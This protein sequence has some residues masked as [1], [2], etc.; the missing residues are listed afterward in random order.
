M[1]SSNSQPPP[2]HISTEWAERYASRIGTPQDIWALSEDEKIW[3]H[4]QPF[5]ESKGYA[6]R[7]RYKPGWVRSWHG[8]TLDPDN[9]E[10]SLPSV[11]PGVMDATRV[12]DDKK[13]MIK[14][15]QVDTENGHDE[16][17]ILRYLA[18]D[19]IQHNPRNHCICAY[20]SF[21]APD[22]P[23]QLFI[24]MPILRRIDDVPFLT[25]G[26][27]TEFMRQ[28]LE[29]LEFMHELNLAHRDCTPPNI[30]MEGSELFSEEP[31]PS[32]FHSR[33]SQDG[34][35]AVRPLSRKN[36]SVRYYYIDYGISSLFP[37][38]ESRRFVVGIDGR[39]RDVPELS[40]EVPYDPFK[41]DVCIL[42][43]FFQKQIIP[44]SEYLAIFSSVIDRMTAHEPEARITA[45]DAHLQF[46]QSLKMLSPSCLT[47]PLQ[48]G[49]I[50]KAVYGLQDA[51]AN[52]FLRLCMMF[53]CR[54]SK[55][56]L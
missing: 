39:E 32:P 38:N 41:T 9:C 8:T 52:I 42:G 53:G 24:V 44:T 51:F 33:V 15:L 17:G 3:V 5:L 50:S 6:L 54:R 10:D 46:Q 25:V 12:S 47:R 11:V 55:V 56:T 26:E 18:A 34:Q 22:H 7:P 1:S 2:G 40:A 43:R 35:R 30:M 14:L 4:Y 23:S 28:L 31:H 20:D 29:G 13:V 16:L 36:A 21:P 45:A 19:H 48:P 37:N 27:V 49:I